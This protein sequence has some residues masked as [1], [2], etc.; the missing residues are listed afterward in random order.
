MVC[1]H[2]KYTLGDEQPKT[3]PSEWRKS[4][5]PKQHII[6]P[7]Y[8][9]DHSGLTMN[10]TG[11]ACQWDSGQV[12]YI[13]VEREVV[14]EMFGW[15][16][17]T[18][19]RRAMIEKY[20]RDEVEEYDAYLRGEVYEYRAFQDWGEEES[21]LC[22]GYYSWEACETD[23][24]AMVAYYRNQELREHQQTLKAQIANKAPLSTRAEYSTNYKEAA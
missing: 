1:W 15:P 12:G 10:T 17:I 23:A 6:L 5:S 3:P 8:L 24:Q 22:G 20:L 2:S 21:D 16:L 11:F 13:Y 7:L 4:V 14:R 18:K 9:Y 19:G